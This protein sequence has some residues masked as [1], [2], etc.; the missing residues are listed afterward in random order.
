MTPSSGRTLTTAGEPSGPSR[1]DGR[2]ASARSAKLVAAGIL[3]SRISGLIR[4][5]V[6]AQ[7]FA[8]SLYADV[9]NAAL[10]MPN[11]LQNLLGE[12]TLSASFI[13]V[14]AEL[15]ERGRKEEAGRVAGAVFSLLVAAAGGFSLIGVL[16]AP[17]IVTIVSPGFEG[18][19][20]ELTITCVRI[21]FPMTGVLVLSAW[22]LGIQNSHRRFFVS[23]VAPVLWNGAMI[24]TLLF[25]GRRM[26]LADLVV[27]LA[28]GALAGGV[29][30]FAVQIPRV[31]RLERDLKLNWDTR[32][33]G[34]R[35]AV[36]NAGPAVMGRG[37]VQLSG[38]VEM[39]LASFLGFGAVAALGY[40]Q[41]LYLLPVSLFGMSVAVAELPELARARSAE[42]DVL[43]RRLNTGLRQIALFVVP[44]AVGFV[45]LGDVIVAALYQTGEFLRAD[46]IFVWVVLAGYS[47]GLVAS[48]ASRLFSSAYFALHDTKTPAKIAVVRV[49]A[50]A[51]LGTVLMLALRRFE[52]P[53]GHTLG[54]LG[55]SLAAGTAAWLEWSLLRRNLGGR[56][57][58]LGSGRGFLLKL[59]G[60]ATIAALLGRAILLVVPDTLVPGAQQLRY[61]ALAIYALVPYGIAYF[62]L[63]RWAGVDEASQ[64]VDRVV[65]RFR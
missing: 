28:W 57:G 1:S 24:A 7:Y 3:F 25:F 4:Q 43:S 14:Y 65:G 34:V 35:T 45:V 26:D 56:L 13:P 49:L 17:W 6:F 47:L 39:L 27:A 37:V 30:Q 5:R 20:R 55:L 23:Y 64:V 63:A 32:L 50:V 42:V 59:L 52:L 11:V 36:R 22:A 61:I 44:S 8:T 51:A 29:L 21:I 60:A 54:A 58:A 38:Y 48:T 18:L 41:T 16:I 15:L 40:A 2:S 62:V 10:R 12:G 9:F 53:G 46:T 19:R 33:G 31:L